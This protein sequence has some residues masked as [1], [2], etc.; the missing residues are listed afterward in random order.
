MEI[1]K[2]EF[3]GIGPFTDHHVIDFREIGQG[4]LFLLEG[5][6]GSGKT[7]ILDAIVFAL[8]GD[9]AG[10]DSSKGRIVSSM[11]NPERE[12]FVDLVIDSSRGLLRVR[13]T[14]EFERP[15]LRGPGTTTS[16][17]TMKLWKLATPD[18][19]VGAPVSTSIAEASEELQ[20]A[21]G[22]T[23]SQFTQTVMLPQGHFATFLR[24]KP[25]E[26]RDV[27]QDIFG[28]ELF[29]RFA[30]KLAEAAQQYRK[31]EDLDRQRAVDLASAFCQVAWYDDA[32]VATEPIA[33]QVA[34]DQARDAEDLDGLLVGAR[35]RCAVLACQW[36]AV[37]QAADAASARHDVAATTLRALEQRNQL[38][39][40]VTSLHRRRTELQGREP[41]IGRDQA[42]LAAAERAEHV[43]RPITNAEEADAAV[44]SALAGLTEAAD[45]VRSGADADLVE[46]EPSADGLRV[47]EDRA[48]LT[49]GSL[50]RLVALERGL[51]GRVAAAA[52]DRTALDQEGVRIGSGLE[53]VAESRA[54]AAGLGVVLVTREEVAATVAPAIE[55]LAAATGR[56]DAARQVERLTV[57]LTG[58]RDGEIVAEQQHREAEQRHDE[59]RSA[60][61]DGLAG[62]LAAGLVE[63]DPCAVCGSRS[64][65]APAV[66]PHGSVDRDE[67]NALAGAKD[68][69]ARKA[70][71][72]RALSDRIAGQLADQVALTEGM[73]LVEAEAGH[74][75]AREVRQEAQRAAADVVALRQ[76]IASI[77]Q[78]ADSDE[79]NLRDAETALAGRRGA[80]EEA[81]RQLAADQADVT[82]H[83]EGFA[84]VRA[85]QR[86]LTV[87]A[88]TAK[89]LAALLQESATA[90]ADRDR[91][92]GELAAVLDERGFATVEQA[93]VAMVP[94]PERI[95]LQAAV[96]AHHQEVATVEAQL[97]SGRFAGLDGATP[98][99]PGPLRQAEQDADA[100]QR[101]AHRLSGVVEQTVNSSAQA[102][103]DLTAA[104]AS[105][106]KLREE[107]GPVLRLADLANAGPSNLQQVS[108]PTYVLLRRFEEVVDLANH[109]LDS[110]TAGR[111][112]LRRTDQR[113]GRARRAG[114]GLAVIDHQA[115]DT[116][117][118]PGTL[119]GGETF[120][121]SLALALGLAD[122]VTAEA[123]GIELHTLFV[124]EGF[125]SLDPETLDAVMDQLSA[126][127]DG[128]R[129]VGVVSHV[130]ELKQRIA[131]RI[132]VVPRRDGTSTLLC[133]TDTHVLAG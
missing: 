6:T 63:G 131:E 125:G 93:R 12:P 2:L 76:R 38:I 46:G 111:Y 89:L 4:G 110:M 68:V 21:I 88:E 9:V 44:A 55:A 7:T 49:A 108:L 26:R 36:E 101:N 25:E 53:K 24:A 117:R 42:R 45:G 75:V 34:F 98:E 133:S 17:A 77:A 62:E 10:S 27:L 16:K 87:R 115:R 72:A 11:L 97:G 15:K 13:R 120:M 109:R 14:P 33:E 66:K 18:D 20:R 70:G 119:S 54:E 19:L 123:G 103:Q 35:E 95:R 31:R 52:R 29:E 104:I 92:A 41:E 57:Q 102:S 71:E 105:L 82:A 107:A 32:S 22:L 130:A 56:R 43:R 50:D 83:T 112:E 94:E 69:A 60:W 132:T 113:E 121:A 81:E 1:I 128:G 85:R 118:D 8:Y 39:D 3:Q 86:A 37:R 100:A 96:A 79:R 40:E 91:C 30:K 99:D 61:L 28:T 126:L 90:Q 78:A 74:A 64:H 84:S 5:P 114:L 23:K 65:P 129:S 67:V 124:D 47:Q 122:A 51:A 58:A 48:R 59:A 73:S 116:S 80:L 127:R 106:S